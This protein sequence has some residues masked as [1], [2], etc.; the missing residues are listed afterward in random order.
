MLM[1]QSKL[2]HTF[3]HTVSEQ[4]LLYLTVP[5]RKQSTDGMLSTGS[6]HLLVIFIIFIIQKHLL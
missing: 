4:D 5:Y 2:S 1:S 6:F 3:T